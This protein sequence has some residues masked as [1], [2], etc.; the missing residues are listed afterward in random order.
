[1]RAAHAARTSCS[2]SR[3]ESP[4]RLDSRRLCYLR[5][6]LVTKKPHLGQ[7]IEASRLSTRTTSSSSTARSLTQ[8]YYPGPLTPPP[9]TTGVTIAVPHWLQVRAGNA[10]SVCRGGAPASCPKQ[11]GQNGLSHSAHSCQVRRPS[12][13]RILPQPTHL[14]MASSPLCR[15]ELRR[16]WDGPAASSPETRGRPGAA[17]E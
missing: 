3:H 4:S 11:S 12:I 16:P 7:A 5:T 8:S 10:R 13:P 14:S 2:Y 9:T 17:T 1:M 15:R 6:Q